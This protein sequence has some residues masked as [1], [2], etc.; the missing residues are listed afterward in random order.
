M[1]ACEDGVV[2]LKQLNWHNSCRAILQVDPNG[3]RGENADRAA[4]WY[5]LAV[6]E[7]AERNWKVLDRIPWTCMNFLELDSQVVYGLWSK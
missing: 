5:S 2:R 6:C 4:E 7:E 1:G 3:S